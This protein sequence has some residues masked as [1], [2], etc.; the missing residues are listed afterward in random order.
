M[1]SHAELL[2]ST[3]PWKEF[4]TPEGK[5]YFHNSTTKETVW[6]VPDELQRIREQLEADQQQRE[7][8]AATT[9]A[10]LALEGGPEPGQVPATKQFASHEEVNSFS[11]RILHRQ[12]FDLSL[13]QGARSLY[14]DARHTRCCSPAQ[15]GRRTSC[16]D[17]RPAL[18]SAAH[19]G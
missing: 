10:S 7:A 1:K 12:A 13:H 6:K 2:L 16:R 9:A 19:H 5:P 15:V 3:C 17:E 8:P 18:F 14:W 11:C 4:K